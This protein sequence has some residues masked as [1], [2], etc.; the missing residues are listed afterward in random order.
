MWHT[1]EI[2]PSSIRND[3]QVQASCASIDKELEAIYADIPSINF[4][5]HVEDQVEPLL[6]IM[7]WEYHVDFYQMVVDGSPLT[8]E[9]K[10][11]L[12]NA[13]IEWHSHKGTKWVVEEVLRTVWA[14]AKVVEWYEYGGRPYYFK[15]RTDENVA[16]DMALFQRVWEAVM[17]VK[18]VRS[19]LE[20]FI[21][22]FSG[23]AT[24]Y[25]GGIVLRRK[26]VRIPSYGNPFINFLDPPRSLP[27]VN[28][29]LRVIG[30]FFE[31]TSIIIFDGVDVAT[32]FIDSKNLECNISVGY[33]GLKQVQVRNIDMSV[34]NIVIFNVL[35]I[36]VPIIVQLMPP[37]AME[38]STV[39]LFEV[40]GDNFTATSVIMFDNAPLVTTFVSAQSLTSVDLP[41]GIEG[42]YDVQVTDAALVSNIV[43]FEAFGLPFI[44]QLIPAS[45][46]ENDVLPILT[47]VGRNFDPSSSILFDSVAVPTTYIDTMTLETPTLDVGLTRDVDVQVTDARLFMSNVVRIRRSRSRHSP[48]RRYRRDV[49]K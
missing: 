38:L 26:I 4:W 39:P 5:P 1:L 42:I 27:F 13:S 45:A 24:I 40:I 29:V 20:G 41:V 46:Y 17:A 10:V 6:D 36:P 21:K 12:I 28:I 32:T 35:P 22:S 19:W 9:K 25:A 43:T 16:A 31:T 47:V 33:V 11:E 14:T 23:R 7:F 44:T 48:N 49:T 30:S 15:I 3:P 2:V 37:D 18:N 34:S 8:R